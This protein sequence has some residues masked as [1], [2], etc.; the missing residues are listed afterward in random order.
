MWSSVFFENTKHVDVISNCCLKGGH[1]GSHIG[2][3]DTG[4]SVTNIGAIGDEHRVHP[5]FTGGLM[6]LGLT[7]KTQA[8]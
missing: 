2:Q 7:L 5:Q 4:K 8:H 3:G 1:G 6:S